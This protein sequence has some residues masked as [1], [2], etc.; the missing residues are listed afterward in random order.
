MTPLLPSQNALVVKSIYE[1]EGSEIVV[2]KFGFPTN[3]SEFENWC[4]IAQAIYP[5]F[6]I[7]LAIRRDTTG[8]ALGIAGT[9]NSKGALLAAQ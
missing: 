1:A 2:G 7:T 3:Q 8:K 6:L 9:V 4:D 5:E